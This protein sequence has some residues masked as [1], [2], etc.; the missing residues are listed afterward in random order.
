V[1]WEGKMQ[2]R[3]LKLVVNIQHNRYCRVN[4]NIRVKGKGRVHPRTG[5]AGPE[6]E[7]KYSSTLSLTSALYWVGD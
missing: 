5:H 4:N 1:H 7:Q 2:P 6:G 3:V